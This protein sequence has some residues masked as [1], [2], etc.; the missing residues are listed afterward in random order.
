MESKKWQ[1]PISTGRS[2]EKILRFL[3]INLSSYVGRLYSFI[4][5]VLF[6]IL[7]QMSWHDVC[8][9]YCKVHLIRKFMVMLEYILYV[10]LVLTT[11]GTSIFRPKQFTF[12]RQ[13]VF[14]IDSMFELYGARFSKKDIFCAHLQDATIIIVALLAMMKYV[15]DI[16]VNNSYQLIC[17]FL[18]SWYSI[19]CLLFMDGLFIHYVNDIYLRF[20]ELNKIAIQHPRENLSIS[21]VNFIANLNIIQ[22]NKYNYTVITKIRL[23]QHIHHTLYILATKININFGLQLLT[24]FGICLNAIILLL[25]DMYNNIQTESDNTEILIFH[26]IFIFCYAFRSLYISYV[27]QRSRNAFKQ[28]GIILHDV[29]LEYKS[30]RVEVI[31]FSLQLI[32]EDLTFTAFGL[33]EINIPLICSITG[34]IVTYFVMVIQLDTPKLANYNVTIA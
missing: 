17:Y 2:L 10:L 15:Y 25:Y 9:E 20:H 19:V 26:M 8:T 23:I 29:F 7:S 6:F 27:C 3:G 1:L 33:Y 4:L 34:A 32:H 22:C 30:L 14:I 28:M 5:M 31:H 21:Y 18:Q 16:I 11:M 13:E 24:I 12:P